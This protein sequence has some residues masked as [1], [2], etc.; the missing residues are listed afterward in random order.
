MKIA[1]VSRVPVGSYTSKLVKGFHLAQPSDDVKVYGRKGE[2]REEGYIK[3]V[4]TWTSLLF[5]FQIFRQS[6]RDKPQVVHIQH[7]F[8]MF[9]KPATMALVPL[10]YL[11]LR[12]LR[13]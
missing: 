13:V 4:E 11:F 8:G 5:P 12:F 6:C 10:L 1:M 9:G 2:R 7:E 3:L